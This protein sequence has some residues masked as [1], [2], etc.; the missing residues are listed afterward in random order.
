[1]IWLVP[2]CLVL[3]GTL[4]ITFLQMAD[5]LNTSGHVDRYGR[6]GLE[7]KIKQLSSARSHK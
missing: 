1:M 6:T 4:L 3:Y 2:I 5:P 7:G